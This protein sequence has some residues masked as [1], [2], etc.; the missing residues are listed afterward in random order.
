MLARLRRALRW[1]IDSRGALSHRRECRELREYAASF[2]PIGSPEA[3]EY[4][5]RLEAQRQPITKVPYIHA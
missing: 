5:R 2:P 1:L 3:D 4:Y